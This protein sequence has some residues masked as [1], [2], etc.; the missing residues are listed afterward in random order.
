MQLGDRGKRAFKEFS[1]TNQFDVMNPDGKVLTLKGKDWHD[2]TQVDYP[3]VNKQIVKTIIQVNKESAKVKKEAEAVEEAKV[4]FKMKKWEK[5]D[6]KISARELENT[7]AD[8]Y[9]TKIAES[10]K[11]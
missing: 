2:P 3:K 10:K 9:Q 6:P 11:E 7:A 4:P 8:F 1:N 5:V